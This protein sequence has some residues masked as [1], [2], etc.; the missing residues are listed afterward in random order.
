MSSKL[1]T[2]LDKMMTT[3]T[4]LVDSVKNLNEDLAN[5]T[6]QNFSMVD[7]NNPT[8]TGVG[9]KTN[10]TKASNGISYKFNSTITPQIVYSCDFSDV[11][12]GTYTLCARIRASKNNASAD[13]I[14]TLK[15]TSGSR[16][17]KTAGFKGSDFSKTDN[18]CFL[19]TTF[20]YDG[21]TS[22]KQPIT[23]TFE[24]TTINAIDFYFDYAYISLI[25]P[26]VYA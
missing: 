5:I 16:E 25:T 11:K 23:F 10:D 6:F 13:D 18:Y 8:A 26:A 1:S 14:L 9:I 2:I 4:Y 21:T 20:D 24:T 3:E 7:V 19:C 15:V 12:F 22:A 17:L